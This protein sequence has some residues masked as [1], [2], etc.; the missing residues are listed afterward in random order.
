MILSI[1]YCSRLRNPSG[2]IAVIPLIADCYPCLNRKRSALLRIIAF[3]FYFKDLIRNDH[4][5]C[6]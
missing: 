1:F 4:A 6:L 3:P 2:S 5:I